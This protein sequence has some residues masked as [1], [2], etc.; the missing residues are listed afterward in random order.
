MSLSNAEMYGRRA[1]NADNHEEVGENVKK[2][3]DELIR[4]IRDLEARVSNLER[5]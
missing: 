4:E 1:R 5:R 2:A 3:I